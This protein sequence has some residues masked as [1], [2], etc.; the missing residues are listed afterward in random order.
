MK[1][2]KVKINWVD[3][4]GHPQEQEFPTLKQAHYQERFLRRNHIEYSLSKIED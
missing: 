3:P 1:R 4:F 2:V